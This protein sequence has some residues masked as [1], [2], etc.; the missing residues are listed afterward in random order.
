MVM[1][2]MATLVGLNA[3]H[4]ALASRPSRVA[5]FCA[6]VRNAVVVRRSSAREAATAP[7][8]NSDP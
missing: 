8:R 7:V 2:W 5:L 3:G 4:M 1:R 6:S